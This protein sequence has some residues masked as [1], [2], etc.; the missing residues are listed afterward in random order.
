MGLF[1][2]RAEE[3]VKIQREEIEIIDLDQTSEWSKLDLERELL[4]QKEHLSRE[5]ALK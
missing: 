4:K 1:F 3:E 2:K 5:V